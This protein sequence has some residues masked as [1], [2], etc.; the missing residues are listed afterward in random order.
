MKKKNQKKLK[1]KDNWKSW[2]E[3][4]GRVLEII[5]IQF[6]AFFSLPHSNGSSH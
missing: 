4:I 3:A 2:S 1:E 5:R 6:P